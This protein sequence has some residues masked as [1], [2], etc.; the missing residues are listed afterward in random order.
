MSFKSC[1][2]CSFLCALSPRI[3]GAQS[4]AAVAQ[5]AI[6]IGNNNPEGN[7]PGRLRFAD[8]DAVLTNQLLLDAGVESH[9][10]VA[11]DEDTRQMHPNFS[12][13]GA[14]RLPDLE[15]VFVAVL[16]KMQA[17]IKRG[18]KT[19]LLLFYS[20]HG[21][22]ENGE[23]YVVLEGARLT[24]TRLFDLLSRSPATRNHVFVDACKSYFLVYAKGPGGQ[25][26]AFST[27]FVS[28]VPGK[29]ANTGFVLS[30]SSDHDSHEW[31]RYQAGIFSHELR[32]ALRGAADANR[33]G[34]ISYAELGAFLTVANISIKNSKL[35]PD[36][37]VSPPA[38]SP[39]AEILGWNSGT[40]SLSLDGS[41]V[42]HLYLETALGERLLDVHPANGEVVDLHLPGARPLFVHKDDE[43]AEYELTTL[44]PEDARD[45]MDH[46]KPPPIRERG[47]V[48]LALK[49]LFSLPF[50]ASNVSEFERTIHFPAPAPPAEEEVP[51]HGSLG[52]V[53]GWVAIG[54]GS[55]ALAL[56]ATS[57]ATSLSD[58][59]ASQ[60]EIDQHN[61]RVRTLNIASVIGYSIA[62]VAG[63]TWGLTRL[64]LGATGATAEGP[65]RPYDAR[66]LTLQ[67]DGHF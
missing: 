10:L 24:R 45:A 2:V 1:L 5:F 28:A 15:R 52:T 38:S 41:T 42:G 64:Q 60:V 49:Q 23:G 8:D 32:S 44:R 36:F 58:K 34:R 25:R 30:T 19:E 54:A 4:N 51:A 65:R 50:G 7:G 66:S 22:A 12:P 67:L 63:L 21:D 39:T 20:G 35:R 13:D 47:S 62:A 46:P 11:P 56:S 57:L 29:L 55:A 59:G 61:Q 3:A 6:V 33:D 18:E 43:S 53:A 31:D 9:L 27:P 37:M 40:V 17:H 26:T 14:P 48:N 16:R